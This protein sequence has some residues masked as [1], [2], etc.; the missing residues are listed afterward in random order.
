MSCCLINADNGS[1]KGEAPVGPSA[2]IVRVACRGF[3]RVILPRIM[4]E[5]SGRRGP[6][7]RGMDMVES[8]VDLEVEGV[9]L[10]GPAILA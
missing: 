10:R 7:R 4:V 8:L 6:V 1:R 5:T 3:V 2:R 9:V